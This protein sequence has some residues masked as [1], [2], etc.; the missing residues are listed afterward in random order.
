MEKHRLEKEREELEETERKM[1]EEVERKKNELR[2]KEELAQCDFDIRASTI[3]AAEEEE[4][5]EME[6]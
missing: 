5:A 4:M 6:N 2:R 3:E 1:K